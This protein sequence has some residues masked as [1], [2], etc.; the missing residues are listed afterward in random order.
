MFLDYDDPKKNW[1]LTNEVV[2]SITMH[3]L[4]DPDFHAC[5]WWGLCTLTSQWHGL[6]KIQKY[7]PGV[8]SI[9]QC[10]KSQY[11]R[12]SHDFTRKDISPRGTTVAPFKC[13]AFSEPLN[14]QFLWK[15]FRQLDLL[16]SGTSWICRLICVRHWSEYMHKA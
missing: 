5:Y 7:T 16:S 15:S 12:S 3:W 6:L 14:C 10:K 2:P 9:N 8:N 4:I 1:W 11:L 13:F